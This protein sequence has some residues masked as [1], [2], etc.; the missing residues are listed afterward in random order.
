MAEL[1]GEVV[2]DALAASRR[3]HD[4]SCPPVE[5]DVE[6]KAVVQSDQSYVVVG[7]PPA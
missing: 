2:I 3:G 5:H 1:E 6:R 7:Y 4:S